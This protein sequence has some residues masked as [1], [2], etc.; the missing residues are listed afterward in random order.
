VKRRALTGGLLVF[1]VLGAFWAG[2]L[3]TLALF[4]T[5]AVI[6]VYELASMLGRVGPAIAAGA[7][8]IVAPMLG[9]VAMVYQFGPVL[10][11]AWFFLVWSQDTGAY[12]V[13]K[14]LGLGRHKMWPQH[15]PGKTW[16]GW[17]GGTLLTCVLAW[18]LSSWFPGTDLQ[19]NDWLWLAAIVAIFG[20]LGD[21]L[22]SVV[23]RRCGVSDSGTLLPGH[24]G[25]LDRFDAVFLALP[26]SL[27]YLSFAP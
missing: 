24:G 12:L 19:R 10:A 22:E 2:P 21:L 27:L 1:A 9:V 16:E 5:L 20:T 23:K 11:M 15:S 17:A 6:G 14:S 3:M 13:G 25:V 18:Q 4:G 7:L 26:L 8:W